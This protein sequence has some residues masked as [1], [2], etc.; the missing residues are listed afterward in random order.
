[1]SSAT[2]TETRVPA[3]RTVP[4]AGWLLPAGGL[5]FLAGGMF[6]PN[7]D[8][9]EL[10][11]AQQMRVMY[12]DS[13]WYPAHTLMAV[14]A[15]LLAAALV[16]LVRGRVLARDDRAHKAAVAAAVTAMISAPV[17]LLHLVAAVEADRIARGDSHPLT[18]VVLVAD[19]VTVPLFGFAVAAL[20]IL[21]AARRTLGN[22]VAA[23]FGVVGGVGYALASGTAVFTSALD[24][25]FP[26]ALGVAAWAVVA[27]AGLV[28]RRHAAGATA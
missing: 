7:E 10:G 19:T 21:G 3:R 9:P 20:A 4:P 26:T 28:T 24:P 15:F 1:M 18:D 27:G 22:P 17:A 8:R 16:A 2:T 6:H 23:A 12:E 11:M 13:A 25:L 14:G 5:F